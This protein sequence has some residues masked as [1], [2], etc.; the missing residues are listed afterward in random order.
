M[1]IV[2]KMIN[3]L[4]LYFVKVTRTMMGM[5][6]FLLAIA[7][8]MLKMY[9][10]SHWFRSKDDPSPYDITRDWFEAAP[11][12]YSNLFHHNDKT[13]M[14]VY[15]FIVPYI[16][17]AFFVAL[18][19]ALSIKAKMPTKDPSYGHLVIRSILGRTWKIPQSA[20]TYLGMPRHISTTE[21]LG[22]TVFLILNIGTFAVRVKRSLPRGTRKLN[23]LVD[24]DE[25]RGNEPISPVSWEACEIWGK[26]LGVLAIMNL[27]WYLMLPMGRRSVILEATNVSWEHS[28]KYHRWV[29]YWT[30]VLVL[31]HCSMYVAVW[32]HGNGQARFDPESLMIHHNLVPWGCNTTC[33][34]EQY[35]QLRINFFGI[36]AFIFMVIMVVFSLPW[37]RRHRFELFYYTHH[38]FVLVLV[39]LCLHYPGSFIY[40]IP[41]VAV[42]MVDK[43]YPLFA[44]SSVGKVQTSLVSPDVLEVSVPTSTQCYYGG[45][46]VFLNCPA[47]SWLQW[48]PFSLT[49]APCK[50]KDHLTF[51]IKAA[52]DWTQ[53]VIDCAKNA[54]EKGGDL[55]VRLDGFYG[56]NAIPSLSQRSAVVLV[57]GGIGVTPM[58][59][60]ATDLLN[61]SSSKLQITLLWVV[62]TVTEFSILADDL[63]AVMKVHDNL[64]VR[65][66]ITMSQSEPALTQDMEQP[67][68]AV[69]KDDVNQLQDQEVHDRILSIL[70]SIRSNKNHLKA[71]THDTPSETSTQLYIFNK[72]GL[73]PITNA[74]IMAVSIIIALSAYAFTWHFEYVHQIASEE[75]VTIIHMAAII[76]S[77]I[78]FVVILEGTRRIYHKHTNQEKLNQEKLAKIVNDSLST[79]ATI[80]STEEEN[81]LKELSDDSTSDESFLISMIKGRIGKRPDLKAE[82]K[83]ISSKSNSDKSDVAVLACG[84]MAMVETINEICNVPSSKCSSEEGTHHDSPVFFTYTEEDWEW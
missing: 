62:R 37:I 52:G 34:E 56:H 26:T 35:R 59:S 63:A 53:S 4:V 72:P 80:E 54:K 38:L 76:T 79:F 40:L 44:Y 61:N 25:A 2:K 81:S 15:F 47:V 77:I 29:G 66:W 41:G 14:R 50:Y 69:N 8:T 24:V 18:R 60:V 74:V 82:F 65:V 84:P 27:A 31:L 64:Q 42:Y 1:K 45:A 32:M 5:I 49:S 10:T 19:H 36:Y 6:A 58:I 21:V 12:P 70:E 11:I 55:E 68:V 23:F 78:V 67:I 17:C 73:Q 3:S 51:H 43:L 39:F 7:P 28:V 9:E 46:Y 22:I 83:S 16:L 20:Q 57:G 33:D 71:T 13:L 48:H 75:I 30:F